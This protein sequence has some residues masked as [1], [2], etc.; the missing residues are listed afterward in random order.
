MPTDTKRQA[1]AE[2][3]ELLRSSSAM[4]VV[5]YRGLKV[6]DMQQVRRTLRERGVQLHIAKN[7]LLKIAADEADR[8]E[9]KPALTGPTALATIT[10]DEAAM[11][12]AL[13]DALR[14]YTRIVSL[15]GGMLGN[16]AIDA[17]QL[18]RLATLPPRE[19]LLS[20]LAGGMAGPMTNMAGVLAAN[21][22]NL[23]GVLSAV[24]DKKRATETAA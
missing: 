5:D 11:A 6:A 17:A 14:P 8:A 4:A 10:G 13:A 21:L 7:R 3:A 20:R 19:V 23:V 15:R 2:L 1:V 24:A 9:L 22:R 12:K 16:R 18:T